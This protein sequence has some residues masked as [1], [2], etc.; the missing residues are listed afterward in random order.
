MNLLLLSVMLVLASSR[1]TFA[2][3]GSDLLANVGNFARWVTTFVR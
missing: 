1:I 3:L 2:D